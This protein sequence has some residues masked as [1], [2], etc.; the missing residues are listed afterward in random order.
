[1]KYGQWQEDDMCRALAAVRKGDMGVIEA[2]RT[3]SVPR[4]TLQ[5]HLV[6]KNYFAV[7]HKKIIDSIADLRAEVEYE[8]VGHV[9]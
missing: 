5:R 2:A 4:V 8:L 7:K 9:L 3:Y 6:G 1:M